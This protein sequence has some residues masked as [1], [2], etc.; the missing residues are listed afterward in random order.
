MGRSAGGRACRW[1]AATAAGDRQP[2]VGAPWPRG[3]E[4]T[5]AGRVSGRAERGNPVE[6][7]A[8]PGKPTAREA[9]LLCGG[10]GWSD[11]PMPAGR[12]ATG[13]RGTRAVSFSS[14]LA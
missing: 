8:M 10:K 13:N 1:K 11:K 9:Q 7:R 6:V 4:G 5:L 2:D 3:R 12:K 14:R